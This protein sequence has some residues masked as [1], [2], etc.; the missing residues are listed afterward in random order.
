MFAPVPIPFK[1]IDRPYVVWSYDPSAENAEF[2]ESI[3][4]DF[5]HRTIKNHFCDEEG[6]L[7]FD[8]QDYEARKDISSLARLIW[9]HGLETLVTLLGAYVQA[10]HAVHG[11]FLKCENKD[12]RQIAKYLLVGRIPESNCLPLPNFNFDAFV[13]G[14]HAKTIW[15]N[16][17]ATMRNFSRALR[18]MLHEYD[19]DDFRAEYNSIKHGLRAHHGRFA[20]AFGLQEAPGKPAPEENMTM[21][22]DSPD[23]SH[24]LTTKTFPN[25]TKKLA[26]EQFSLQRSSVGW[27]LEKTLFDIQLFSSLIG[28]IVAALKIA[29][30]A[31]PGSLQFFRPDVDAEWWRAYFDEQGPDVQSCSFSIDI[32]L[33]QNF[34]DAEKQAARFYREKAKARAQ[35]ANRQA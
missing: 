24:F 33:T 31:M 25:L 5:Y 35:P 4:S 26:R 14:I 32:E 19:R 13:R 27:S 17:E 2:L 30:G 11:F 18:D 28:N 22:S 21:I 3:D 23:G 7:R 29:M 16:D 9:N 15:V 12:C 8:P 10:P 1:V 20:M 34:D 6:K